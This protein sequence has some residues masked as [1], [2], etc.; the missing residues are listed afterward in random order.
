MAAE[1][2]QAPS[3]SRTNQVVTSMLIG[4]VIGLIDVIVI[5]S[6][7]A[8]IFSGDLAA[9]VPLGI[10]LLLFAGFVNHLIVTFTTSFTGMISVSQDSPAALLGIEL[11]VIASS[12]AAGTADDMLFYTAVA[13]IAL[14][15]LL[16]GVVFILLGSFKL[17]VL[18]R[19]FPYPVIAGFLAGTGWFL[20]KGGLEIAADASIGLGMLGEL[21]SADL[22]M[23]WLPA[24]L[25]GIFF[26]WAMGRFTQFWVLPVLFVAAIGLFY[27]AILISGAS[28]QEF[29]TAGWF[30]K[31]FGEGQTW[32]PVVLEAVTRAD[33]S[34]VLAHLQNFFPVVIV[35]V[36][37]MLLNVSGIELTVRKD[38]NLDHELKS[39]GLANLAGALLGNIVSY[40]T[41]SL[42]A[43]GQRSGKPS[44]WI[45]VAAGLVLLLVLLFGTNLLAFVPKLVVGGILAFLG[46][47]FLY[48][49]LVKAYSRLSKFDYAIIWIILIA[50][51]MVGVL[52]GVGIGLLLALGL[53]VYS[54]SRTRVIKHTLSDSN[55]R[56]NVDRSQYFNRVL[57]QHHEW[58]FILELQG[59]VFFGTGHHL[60]EAIKARLDEGDALEPDFIVLDFRQVVGIDVS[61]IQS[62][63]RI[64]Q[65]AESGKILLIF[66]ALEDSLRRQLEKDVLTE[67]NA[68]TWRVFQ[69]LDFAAEWCEDQKIKAHASK[70]PHEHPAVQAKY[71]ACLVDFFSVDEMVDETVRERI[72]SH[73]STYLEEVAFPA[74]ETLI[75]QGEFTKGLYFIEEGVTS[76]EITDHSGK[77]KRLR[78]MQPGTVVGEIGLYSS[79]RASASV[80]AHEDCRVFFLSKAKL[81]QMER[82]DQE[83]AAELHRFIAQ[84]LSYRI[85]TATHTIQALLD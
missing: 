26:Y 73:L 2:S 19:Y 53:F 61:A 28:V 62:F 59:F 47:D 37:S 76:A 12:M 68:G 85:T 52:E 82:A 42:S 60:Y 11:A 17:G 33:W 79:D 22:M 3:S 57:N 25:I 5:V 10:S 78:K 23:R 27:G 55:Y 45:G 7:G 13:A 16:T 6:F 29:Q 70:E 77:A 30:L 72:L 56:S 24:L 20:F 40:P 4:L 21:F 36:I 44:K 64:V 15:T 67:Q 48:T 50:M 32:R 34:W 39:S 83:A 80:V 74:G 66:S 38:I 1:L 81:R 18:V 31:P 65:L 58:L 9:Y 8:L 69:D 51:S 35:S 43:L 54:Y 63:Q 46:I 41:L 14:T 75:Q 49:W 84:L 71:P